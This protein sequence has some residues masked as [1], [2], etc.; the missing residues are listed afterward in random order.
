VY[1]AGHSPRAHVRMAL[2]SMDGEGN[3]ERLITQTGE[4]TAKIGWNT[5]ALPPGT[6]IAADTYWLAAQTDDPLVTYRVATDDR[7]GAAVG[8]TAQSYGEFPD[9]VHAWDRRSG[10]SVAMY[11]LTIASGDGARDNDRMFMV[12]GVLCGIATIGV[13]AR[14]LQARDRGQRWQGA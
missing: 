1:I 13:A 5:F 3:P 8:W 12:I 11:G 7:P 10:S 6:D 9:S 2:Y 14:H 4:R